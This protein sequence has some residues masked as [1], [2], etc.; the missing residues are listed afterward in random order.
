MER[1]ERYCNLRA[2]VEA[3]LGGE[4]DPIMWMATLACLIREHLGFFWVG[5]YRMVDGE[6]LVGP[7]QGTLGC[8][9]ITLER[10]V[11]GACAMQKRTINVSDVHQFPGHIA[12]DERS[13][14]EIVVPVFDAAGELRAVLDIDSDQLDCFDSLDERQLESLVAEMRGLRWDRLS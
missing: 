1:E 7:Y 9:R 5:F 13:Q 8:V 6:L 2:D 10:G 14:S 12:C 4:Q 11:C 3:V